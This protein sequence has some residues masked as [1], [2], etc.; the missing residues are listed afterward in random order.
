M[1]E[2]LKHKTLTASHI[3]AESD[4][5]NTTDGHMMGSV[6]FSPGN[7]GATAY[8][9][10]SNASATDKAFAAILQASGYPVWVCDGVADE[11][12][13]KAAVAAL[14]T[15][16]TSSGRVG[17]EIAIIGGGFVF[18]AGGIEV[19]EHISFK[20]YGR[21]SVDIRG[22]NAEIFHFSWA[23]TGSSL[24]GQTVLLE[25]ILFIGQVADTSARICRVTDYGSPV[26]RNIMATNVNKVFEIEGVSFSAVVD[27]IACDNSSIPAGSIAVEAAATV[28]GEP[29]GL[30]VINSDIEIF[31]TGVKLGAGY[32]QRVIDT[33]FEGCT[34]HINST[35]QYGHK[36]IGNDFNLATGQTAISHS[37]GQHITIGLNHFNGTAGT[38]LSLAGG[39]CYAING[40]TVNLDSGGGTPAGTFIYFT[41]SSSYGECLGNTIYYVATFMTSNNP[42]QGQMIEVG[43]NH[44]SSCVTFILPVISSDVSHNDVRSCSDFIDYA[45]NCIIM[46]NNVLA[47]S[48]APARS[49]RAYGGCI[50]ADNKF[51]TTTISYTATDNV[52]DNKG[53]V[54]ENHGVASNVT[55]DASG[56]GVIAHGCAMT[57]TYANVICQDENL[58]VR[59]SSID[60]TNIN[61][62]VFDLAGA[63]VTADTH[64]FYWDVK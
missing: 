7:L 8:V 3:L 10:A 15:T 49:V 30:K 29:N 40:N 32:E 52:H 58:S 27:H 50:V 18:A 14:P 60:A 33:Y 41:S 51:P 36:Y 9:V 25:N 47:I 56:V 59:I 12:Q 39:I 53:F 2:Y 20:G 46:G 34:T 24:F 28:A 11:V 4:Y 64:D 19:T 57:P 16:N 22:V 13:W 44:V 38:C 31:E 17:G 45:E 37:G 1:T 23:G 48:G 61:I 63:Y 5:T 35:A 6:A 55:L 42:T 43:F 54:T 21:P 62:V 26:F